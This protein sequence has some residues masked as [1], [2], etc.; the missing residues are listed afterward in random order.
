VTAAALAAALR[1]V[2]HVQPHLPAAAVVLLALV[3]ACAVVPWLWPVTRHITVM[4]HEGAHATMA[5]ATGSSVTAIRFTRLAEGETEV[6]AVGPLAS[7]GT[8]VIGYLGPSAFGVGAAALIKAGYIV[9]VL[10]I[11]LAGLLLIMTV[12][13]QS[14]GIISVIVAVVLLFGVAGFASVGVQVVAAYA[15]TWFLLVSAIRIITV[16]GRNAADAGKLQGMTKIPAGFW[17]KLWL[18]ASVVA[19]IFGAT[20]LV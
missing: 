13:R 6:T 19:L 5:S 2:G 17:S 7:F 4:A 16:R 15:L 3:A 12:L 9:A 14:F 1:R 20:L 10:W 11:G 8:T 18:T